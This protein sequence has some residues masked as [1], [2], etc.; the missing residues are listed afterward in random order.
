MSQPSQGTNP[1]YSRSPPQSCPLVIPEHQTGDVI[2][3]IEHSWPTRLQSD[4][5]TENSASRSAAQ[6]RH[7]SSS[8]KSAPPLRHNQDRTSGIWPVHLCIDS[9]SVSQVMRCRLAGW[10]S[11]RGMLSY[12]APWGL[13]RQPKGWHRDTQGCCYG[14]NQWSPTAEQQCM[15]SDQDAS[16]YAP[17]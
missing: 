6:P 15:C 8:K 1:V 5:A 2:R 16:E 12:R 9:K 17:V 3:A 11:A 13:W 10:A 14:G 4:V 7:Q